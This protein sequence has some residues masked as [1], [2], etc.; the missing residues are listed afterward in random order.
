MKCWS[1][2][3]CCLMLPSGLAQDATQENKRPKVTRIVKKSEASVGRAY[4]NGPSIDT[5]RQ[6][7]VT[8]HE[9]LISM[10]DAMEKQ[11]IVPAYA[12]AKSVEY[13][14]EVRAELPEQVVKTQVRNRAAREAAR[15][16]EFDTR[17]EGVAA[18]NGHY[19][20]E[21][22]GDLGRVN[23]TEDHRRTL[24]ASDDFKSFSDTPKRS[25]SK[26]A[27]LNSYQSY[28]MRH[29]GQLRAN[30]LE[31]GQWR[32][33]YRGTGTYDGRDVDVI[34]IY[35]NRPLARNNEADKPNRRK[36]IQ[37]RKLWTF[38]QDGSYEIWVYKV[39]KLPAVIF[40]TNTDDRIF[41]NMD[42][43]YN[44]D[45]LPTR[46]DFRNNSVEADGRGDVIFTYDD[47]KMLSGIS[48][49][50]DGEKGVSIRLDT[51]LRFLNLV[52]RDAFRAIPPFGYRKI[53]KDHLK[54][55]IM[56][57]VSGGLLKLR[58]HGINFRNFK[59]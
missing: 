2:V 1:L 38:W 36:P 23:I 53:N 30:V 20:M 15:A 25:R 57:Q 10:F 42:F 9:V 12:N 8:P 29:L 3:L 5:K 41:A 40:Y 59:F 18:P 48:F 32:T 35:K 49:N 39:S 6:A 54:I 4:K 46:I 58:K 34:R 44:R 26:D 31:S 28:L 16:V 51:T 37:M 7:G 52:E 56:T 14:G 19:R 17:I 33:L 47:Q 21:M 27:N 45:W 55:M 50:F 43:I 22:L 24:V 11:W 13:R